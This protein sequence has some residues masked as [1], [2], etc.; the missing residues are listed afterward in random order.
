MSRLQMLFWELLHFILS[1]KEGRRK[2]LTNEGL[3]LAGVLLY[4]SSSVDSFSFHG[5]LMPIRWREIPLA[6]HQGFRH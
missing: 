2:R 1:G 5:N 4:T 3:S 6:M